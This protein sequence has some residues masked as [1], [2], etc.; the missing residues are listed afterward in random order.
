MNH[1]YLTPIGFA[2]AVR[3]R[4]GMLR[5]WAKRTGRMSRSGAFSYKPE[6]VPSYID[7]PTN[8]ERSAAQVIEFGLRPLQHGQRYGAYLSALKPEHEAQL[9]KLTGTTKARGAITT[10]TGE[11]LAFVTRIT[12][13]NAVCFGRDAGMKGSFWAI[14]IDGRTYYGRHNGRGMYCSMRLAKWADE[15]DVE[16]RTSE[17]WE[18]VCSAHTRAKANEDVRSYRQNQPE[19][20]VRI[21]HRKV[22]QT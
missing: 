13:Y 16:Q 1:I 5:A 22:R 10:W 19:Y 17:G 2:H 18:V 4:E 8:D 12:S 11:P 7:I 6:D 9:Y 15:Y 21:K 14:G 20:A 3:Y